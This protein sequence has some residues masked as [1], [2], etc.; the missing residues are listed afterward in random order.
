MTGDAWL[1][2]TEEVIS[3]NPDGDMLFRKNHKSPT[4]QAWATAF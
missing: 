2:T 4:G 1:T 3:L